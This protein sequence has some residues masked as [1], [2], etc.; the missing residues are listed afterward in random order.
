[1]NHKRGRPKNRRAGCKLRKPAKQNGAKQKNK[2]KVE[3]LIQ[4]YTDSGVEH[5]N[6]PATA[7]INCYTPD[8]KP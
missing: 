3:A 5:V 7:W 6:V 4:S 2:P 1:M 8:K